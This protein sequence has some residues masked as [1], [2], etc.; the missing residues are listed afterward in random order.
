M[1][2]IQHK[3]P[4]AL[5]TAEDTAIVAD[6]LTHA[7]VVHLTDRRYTAPS[8]GEKQH[9]LL[10]RALAQQSSILVLDE[11]TNHLDVRHQFELFD[12]ITST[13]VIVVAALHDLNLAATYCDHLYVLAGERIVAWPPARLLT[14]SLGQGGVRR[15]RPCHQRPRGRTRPSHSPPPGAASAR[16]AQ[17]RSR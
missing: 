2:R 14:P 17:R 9:V 5:D 7:R 6:A 1:G 3:R 13:G 8:G 15:R 4:S 10:A 16:E 11:P 12:L